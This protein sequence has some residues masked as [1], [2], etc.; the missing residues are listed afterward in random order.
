MC[1]SRCFKGIDEFL[2]SKGISKSELPKKVEE[3]MKTFTMEG[4]QDNLMP[5]MIKFISVD[6]IEEHYVQ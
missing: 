3:Y 4:L 2:M 6:I 1:I 5:F